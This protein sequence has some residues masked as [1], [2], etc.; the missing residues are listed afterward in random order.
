[1]L[2]FLLSCQ[3]TYGHADKEGLFASTA[4]DLFFDYATKAAK[5]KLQIM[6][7]G[8]LAK[9]EDKDAALLLKDQLS[10]ISY[11][12]MMHFGND[13]L[14][15]KRA[16]QLKVYR[17]VREKVEARLMEGGIRLAPYARLIIEPLF[18]Y[19]HFEDEDEEGSFDS[20]GSDGDDDA[21]EEAKKKK[22]G[23]PKKAG[24][25]LLQVTDI[26]FDIPLGGNIDEVTEKIKK[27]FETV[28]KQL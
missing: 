18:A 4:I 25:P 13:V 24:K 23:K 19:N 1:M 12:L 22:S 26:K 17:R 16:D 8:P 20:Y 2:E 27:E 21:E 6:T 10:G 5:L 11:I 7:Q 14:Y 3:P 9:K 15:F 28:A